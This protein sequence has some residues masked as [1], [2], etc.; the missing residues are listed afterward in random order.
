MSD[1]VLFDARDDGVAVVTYER[2]EIFGPVLVILGYD[3]VDD[4]IKIANDTDFGEKA[5]Q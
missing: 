5:A 2:E 1:A 4:A 3:S